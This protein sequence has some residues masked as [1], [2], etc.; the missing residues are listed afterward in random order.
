VTPFLIGI[1][2]LSAFLFARL[3]EVLH[4]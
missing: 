3:R 2:I 1:A 4:D